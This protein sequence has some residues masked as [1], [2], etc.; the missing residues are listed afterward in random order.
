MSALKK[1]I[2]NKIKKSNRIKLQENL[3]FQ[4]AKFLLESVFKNYFY[5]LPDPFCA[6]IFHPIFETE[7]YGILQSILTVIHLPLCFVIDNLA[8]KKLKQIDCIIMP[9]PVK[10]FL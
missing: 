2:F 5:L 3:L 10:A 7:S 4:D 8:N 1:K 6:P 9:E